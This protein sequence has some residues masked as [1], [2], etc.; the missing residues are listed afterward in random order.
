V[1]VAPDERHYNPPYEGAVWID[2]ETR[3]VLR[4]EQR[5]LSIPRDFPI[6]KAESILEYAFVRI[7]Q[8]TYLLPATG[9]NLG[10]ASGSGSCTRNVIEFRN[11]RK[12][13][14]DSKVKY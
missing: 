5:T 14:A 2:K 7:E 3:R 1:L 6:S 10:C 4:I 13:T 9:E 8:R 11:Y 12:F